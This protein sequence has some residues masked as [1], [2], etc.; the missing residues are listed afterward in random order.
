M[1]GVMITE[2][3]S[4]QIYNKLLDFNKHDLFE[5]KRLRETTTNNWR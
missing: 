5:I 1:I 4:D 2:I 3:K